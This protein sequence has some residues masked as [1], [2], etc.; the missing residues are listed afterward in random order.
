MDET[1]YPTF[2]GALWYRFNVDVPA[3]A[4]G[5]TVKL[6]VPTV[7]TEAHVWMNGKFVGHR[8]YRESYERP[9]DIDMD[10]TA[11][12]EPGKANHITMRV[13]TGLNAAGSPSGLISRAFLYAPK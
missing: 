9:N 13:Y 11:A 1:G 12:L 3:S 10:V 6:Y 5:K 8:P 2:L 7:E 4:K